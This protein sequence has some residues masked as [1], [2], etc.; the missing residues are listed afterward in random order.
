MLLAVDL[1]NK[2]TG[3]QAAVTNII[4][5]QDISVKGDK[6]NLATSVIL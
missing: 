2:H 5:S 3:S 1:Q 6:G 4:Q